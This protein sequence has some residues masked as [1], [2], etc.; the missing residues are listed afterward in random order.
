MRS[1][2]FLT[3]KWVDSIIW[4]SRSSKLYCTDHSSRVKIF[5]RDL[6]RKQRDRAAWLMH[7]KDSLTDAVAENLLDRLEDCKKTF[8]TT[9]CMGG[10][11][12]A[13]RRLLPGHGGIE[14]LVMMDTSYDMVKMCEQAERSS[15]NKTIETSFVVADEEF[16]PIKESS[17]DLV[18]SCLGLHWTNDLP[19]AMIQSRLALKPDGLFLAA[20]LGGETLREL[21]IAC[22]V[23][24]MEREGGISPRLSPLAQVRDA[25]N[26]LTR[27]GFSLPGVDVD[28]YIVRYDSALELIEHL[29]VMGETNALFQKSRVLKR[30]TALATAAIYESMFGEE[31]GTIPA[32]FQVIYMTGWR[33]H[34]SQQKAKRR[35]SA[36]VS[37]QDIQKHF[38]GGTEN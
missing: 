38:G 13:I 37:F 20:I 14:K 24:Q 21:R 32:T 19:G 7:P 9:L 16:L 11:L 28:E 26:L 8:P 15:P 2:S 22:T 36:T 1:G 3:R 29:R 35:G 6:K 17:L 34:P 23:A 30:D 31:D 12:E 18:I 25:G 27:A 4:G 33:E 5:D 10:S